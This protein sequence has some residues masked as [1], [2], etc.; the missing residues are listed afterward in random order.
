MSKVSI[1]VPCYNCAAFLAKTIDSV[2]AQD[3]EEW[4]L[5]LVDDGSTDE[6]PEIV[7][8]YCSTDN[9]IKGVWQ[10]NSGQAKARNFGVA[11]MS[12]LTKY[13]FFLDSDDLLTP[14]AL[15]VMSN[16][17]DTY[18]DVGLVTCEM[19]EI[20]EKGTPGCSARRS[21]WVPGRFFPR[22]L[23]EDE[24][25]TPFITFFCA[26]GQ[27]PFALF[28]KA[29]YLRTTGY[30]DDLSC[31]SCHED[32]DIFCQMALAAKVH[33]LAERLY[34]K[35][36]HGAQSTANHA[37]VQEGYV[38]FRRKWDHFRPRNIEEER[39]LRDAKR[40]YY[41]MHAPLRNLKVARNAFID[42]VKTGNQSS[43]WWGLRL[44]GAAVCGFFGRN[45]NG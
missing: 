14:E 2:L 36:K 23:S 19:Q 9:F 7:R 35:R 21:R 39:V 29:V 37:R 13:I 3:L 6:T 45:Q 22:Q 38:V 43:F 31:F 42:F 30:E 18:P 32:T 11:H 1:I 34:L 20:D 24:R 10:Q 17:L 25:E 44:V 26:T 5:I 8:R 15:Q 33:H 28:R 12:S 40:Y 16:Y 27:G 41:R 4:E